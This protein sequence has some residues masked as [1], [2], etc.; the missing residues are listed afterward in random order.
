MTVIHSGVFAVIKKFPE[1]KD[2]IKRLLKKEGSFLTL[3]EDYRVCKEAL[4]HW[5]L[6]DAKEAPARSREYR[7]LLQE[8]EAEIMQNVNEFQR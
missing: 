1:Q 4:E 6:S 3:C 2:A 8:L 5:D 7:A